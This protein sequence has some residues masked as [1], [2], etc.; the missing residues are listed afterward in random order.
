VV[1]LPH[2][3][4]TAVLQA[5]EQVC[6]GVRFTALLASSMEVQVLV[7]SAE[8]FRWTHCGAAGAVSYLLLAKS[9]V[10]LCCELNLYE[11][12]RW[13]C[14]RCSACEL[15]LYAKPLCCELNLYASRCA[16]NSATFSVLSLREKMAKASESGPLPS[17]SK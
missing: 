7:A 17:F 9:A 1:V 10:P 15:N 14:R 3:G 13:C 2:A 8:R 11:R 4:R 12:F 5:L 6:D 16:P